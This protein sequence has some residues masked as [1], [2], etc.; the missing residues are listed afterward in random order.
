MLWMMH[1][2]ALQS[3]LALWVLRHCPRSL[4]VRRRDARLIRRSRQR[5]RKVLH[6]ITGAHWRYWAQGNGHQE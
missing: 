3:H 1:I 6:Q 4:K 2:L 5:A